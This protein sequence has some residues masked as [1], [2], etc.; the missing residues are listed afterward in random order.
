MVPPMVVG[1]SAGPARDA[2]RAVL[3]RGLRVRRDTRA[4]STAAPPG[5]VRLRRRPLAPPGDTVLRGVGCILRLPAPGG[6]VLRAYATTV[7]D[8]RN[9]VDRSRAVRPWVHVGHGVRPRG[10]PLDD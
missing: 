1:R 8:D 3:L 2:R 5:P 10:N 6:P 9:T 4:A 7:R